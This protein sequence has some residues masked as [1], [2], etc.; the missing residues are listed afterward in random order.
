ML[1]VYADV[2]TAQYGFVNTDSESITMMAGA[3]GLN[4]QTNWDYY[5][6]GDAPG[7]AYFANL[8]PGVNSVT[9][10]SRCRVRSI[11]A[12]T[13]FLFRPGLRRRQIA[14]RVDR[15]RRRDLSNPAER[16]R[17]ER[18]MDQRCSH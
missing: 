9:D 3:L 11:Q 5:N 7:G 13:I 15:F 10:G 18:K 8:N 12:V 4:G 1:L 14:S 16:S 6:G 17:S 2:A